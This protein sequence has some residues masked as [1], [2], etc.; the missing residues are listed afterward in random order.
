MFFRVPAAH[1]LVLLHI[2]SA[3]IFAPTG[4]G[5]LIALTFVSF[6]VQLRKTAREFPLP[7]GV[8]FVM[9]FG[10]ICFGKTRSKHEVNSVCRLLHCFSLL[11]APDVCGAI[12][13][14][15]NGWLRVSI[16]NTQRLIEPRCGDWHRRTPRTGPACH[17][18]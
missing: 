18:Y 6:Q 13:I 16:F 17:F 15:V 12:V 1:A 10:D 2:C 7:N 8:D 14:F 5:S 3:G 9:A 11:S 4:T